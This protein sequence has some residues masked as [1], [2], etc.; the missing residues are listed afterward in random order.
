MAEWLAVLSCLTD[1]LSLDLT[2]S[3]S[4][5]LPLHC[6]LLLL[7]PAVTEPLEQGKALLLT[8]CIIAQRW[9]F[10]HGFST[11]LTVAQDAHTSRQL[12]SAICFLCL[13]HVFPFLGSLFAY[14][15]GCWLSGGISPGLELLVSPLAPVRWSPTLHK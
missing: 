6:F 3:H 4:K 12:L 11:G 8:L 15:P 5:P 2:N 9:T 1:V 13:T 7:V 14:L 10:F